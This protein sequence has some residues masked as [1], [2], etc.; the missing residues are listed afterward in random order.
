MAGNFLVR[1][2]PQRKSG[3]VGLVEVLIGPGNQMPPVAAERTPVS[4]AQRTENKT[5][6]RP[7]GQTQ[8]GPGPTCG[9]RF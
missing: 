7:A 1:L 5:V 6:W 2:P 4:G 9:Q 3:T 8:R